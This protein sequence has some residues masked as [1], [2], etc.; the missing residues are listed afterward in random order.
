MTV[1]C[2]CVCVCPLYKLTFHVLQ[3]DAHQKGGPPELQELANSQTGAR[4]GPRPKSQEPQERVPRPPS[5][6]SQRLQLCA[7]QVLQSH[8]PHPHPRALQ[9]SE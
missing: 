3:T 8:Q 1:D 5:G 6:G 7:P 9:A 2:V 4:E